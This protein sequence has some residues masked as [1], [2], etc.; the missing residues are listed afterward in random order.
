MTAVAW[1]AVP[2]PLL[3]PRP[4]AGAVIAV[5]WATVPLPPEAGAVAAVPSA[6]ASRRR[7]SGCIKCPTVSIKIRLHKPSQPMGGTLWVA[8]TISESC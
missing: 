8:C 6:R 2:L 1:G 7:C 5:A 4:E 3:R